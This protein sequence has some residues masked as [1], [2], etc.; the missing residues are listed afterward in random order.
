MT[1][2]FHGRT[3]HGPLDLLPG[4]PVAFEDVDAAPYFIAAGWAVETDED[5]VVTYDI[6]TIDIDPDTVFAETGKR[7]LGED[8]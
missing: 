3:K 5:P 4:V 7:V 1:I 6:G 8:L 2:V